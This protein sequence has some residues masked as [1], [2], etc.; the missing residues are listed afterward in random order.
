M[1]YKTTLDVNDPDSFLPEI[2][3]TN[4]KKQLRT[5]SL[6]NYCKMNTIFVNTF[7]LLSKCLFLNF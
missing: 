4:S 1:I 5:H 3:Y 6:N 7:N 2:L